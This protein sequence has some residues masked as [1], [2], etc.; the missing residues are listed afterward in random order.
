MTPGRVFFR[1]FCF[2]RA[3]R[4]DITTFVEYNNST[5]VEQRCYKEL[6]QER[7]RD[8]RDQTSSGK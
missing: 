4:L 2:Y 5:N 7:R 8:E 1:V 6:K 3:Y